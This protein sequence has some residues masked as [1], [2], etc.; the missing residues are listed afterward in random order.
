MCYTYTVSFIL[1]KCHYQNVVACERS[2]PLSEIKMGSCKGWSV[3]HL[4]HWPQKGWSD[5]QCL[6]RILYIKI[7][8]QEFCSTATCIILDWC[9]LC[10]WCCSQRWWFHGD[11]YSPC[12][13]A[14]KSSPCAHLLEWLLDSTTRLQFPIIYSFRY[15]SFLRIPIQFTNY[16][17]LPRWLNHPFYNIREKNQ[18]WLKAIWKCSL[19]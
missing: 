14:L 16:F 6:N 19:I 15:F 17:G 9:H 10:F 2:F 11:L 3:L 5:S 4:L 13:F 1:E 8:L 12:R 18:Q 7:L